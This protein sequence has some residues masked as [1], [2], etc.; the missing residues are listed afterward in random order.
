MNIKVND[1]EEIENG[2][3][4]ISW[5]D[6]YQI[7]M[8]RGCD[9]ISFRQISWFS[10]DWNPYHN[11]ETYYQYPERKLKKSLEIQRLPSEVDSLYHEVIDAYNVGAYT[12][13]AGGLRAL[14]EAVCS[15][16][17]IKKGNVP[18]EKSDGSI[19]FKRKTNLEG[20]IF[21]LQESG[22]IS[23]KQIDVLHE[24]RFLGNVALHE[25]KKPAQ[26][27]IEVAFKIIESLLENIFG[28]EHKSKMLKK[29]R[30][31]HG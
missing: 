31:R 27:Q 15:T 28:M 2:R 16:K 30:E 11:G 3:Y 4:S 21:G 5:F 29:F 9:T 22:Y 7:I 25:I 18:N 23:I 24:L 13:A 10:E 8:C 19:E 6:D 17:G 1:D 14:I 26:D 20:K 12:L